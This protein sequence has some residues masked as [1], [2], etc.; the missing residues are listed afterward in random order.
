M[1]PP[2]GASSRRLP[3]GSLRRPPGGRFL[4]PGPREAGAVGGEKLP[5]PKKSES[6]REEDSV[7]PL[8]W[9]KTCLVVGRSLSAARDEHATARIEESVEKGAFAV[10]LALI[11]LVT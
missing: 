8:D 11:L 3:G 6:R 7:S 9:H 4:H 5:L 2:R 10:K 1:T